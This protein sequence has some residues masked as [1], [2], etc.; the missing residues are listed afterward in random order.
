MFSS[1][2]NP[3]RVFLAKL[4]ATIGIPLG[5]NVKSAQG[6]ES[7]SRVVTPVPGTNDRII[8]N[9][10]QVLQVVGIGKLV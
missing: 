10:G 9:V 5:N 3:G 8:F 2:A 6:L 4:S 7:S 1:T